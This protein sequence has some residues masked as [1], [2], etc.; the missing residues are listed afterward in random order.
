MEFLQECLTVVIPIY[1]GEKYLKKTIAAVLGA[2]YH[3]IEVL[4]IDDGSTDKSSE[5]CMEA[6]QKDNRVR[7]IRQNNQGIVAAR[8]KGLELAR[9]EFICFCDQDDLTDEKMYDEILRKMRVENAQIGLCSTGQIFHDKEKIP[10]EHVED[11]VYRGE[12]VKNSLLYPLLFRGYD[13]PFVKSSNYIYGTVWKC[14]FRRKFLDEHHIKFRKFIN[15]EDDWIFVTETLS[16]VSCA[17]ACG[18]QGYYWRINKDSESRSKVFIEDIIGKMELY[19]SYVCGFLADCIVDKAIM[20]EYIK[21]SLCE[22][23]VDLYRNEA[24]LRDR[25]KKKAYHKAVGGYLRKVDYKTQLSCRRHLRSSAFRRKLLYGSLQYFGTDISFY[26][27]R[28]VDIL[29]GGMSNIRGVIL[30]DRKA[31]KV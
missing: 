16:H 3:N 18:F 15:Y 11:A 2:V 26:T 25:K 5:I 1:N 21:I 30:L 19:N 12:E 27:S 29:E 20:R 8:N 17:A 14:I 13:Y 6:A 23:F 22:N 24:A 9:G 31:K 7:Y 28:T 4:L 10:Y